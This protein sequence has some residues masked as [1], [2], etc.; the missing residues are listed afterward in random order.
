VQTIAVTDLWWYGAVVIARDHAAAP[1]WSMVAFH[2]VFK[3]SWKEGN[4]TVSYTW[5]MTFKA[6]SQ[7]C[8]RYTLRLLGRVVGTGG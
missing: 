3:G 6:V 1:K 7:F 4:G 8:F 2:A 5:W